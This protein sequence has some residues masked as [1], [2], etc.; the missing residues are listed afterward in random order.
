MTELMP[1]RVWF[2]EAAEI[3]DEAIISAMIR[4]SMHIVKQMTMFGLPRRYHA[5]VEPDRQWFTLPEPSRYSGTD[6]RVFAHLWPKY[7]PATTSPR[8]YVR[9]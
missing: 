2:N 5:E 3:S 8:V 7:K 9:G 1:D 4:D 6:R